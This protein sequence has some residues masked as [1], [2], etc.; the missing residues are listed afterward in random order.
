[1]FDA[2]LHF[3]DVVYLELIISLFLDEVLRTNQANGVHAWKVPKIDLQG[4]S[5]SSMEQGTI[6]SWKE[7]KHSNISGFSP[8]RMYFAFE[9]K[10]KNYG[11]CKN[12]WMMFWHSLQ[13]YWSIKM[14]LTLASV[15]HLFKFKNPFISVCLNL[16]IKVHWETALEFYNT[17]FFVTV[18]IPLMLHVNINSKNA[19]WWTESHKILTY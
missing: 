2:V 1:M 18:A 3:V 13:K 15:Q 6:L 4:I 10:R 8:C 14:S 5:C 11:R 16:P 12:Q 19:Q 17:V 9:K 7:W